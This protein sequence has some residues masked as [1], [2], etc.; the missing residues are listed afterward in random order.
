M[1]RIGSCLEDY[2]KAISVLADKRGE[3]RVTD[4]ANRL[5]VSK[6][7]ALSAIKS[8]EDRGLVIHERYRSVIMTPKGVVQAA[9]IRERYYFLISFLQGIV[10]ISFEN[11]EKDACKLEHILSRETLKKMKTLAGGCGYERSI[12]RINE[13]LSN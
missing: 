5:Q 7:S 11:A 12:A 8:L 10:G 1:E 4:I 2:L 3:V 13:R 9:N 6:P